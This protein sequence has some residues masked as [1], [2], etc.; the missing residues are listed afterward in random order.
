MSGPPTD[1]A[2]GAAAL[3]R[4]A[5]TLGGTGYVP[6]APGTAGSAVGAALYWTLYQGGAYWP[7]AVFPFVVILAVWSG[8]IVE[9]ETGRADPS[10]VVVDEAAG[11]LLCLMGFAPTAPLLV[12]GFLVFRFFDIWKPFRRIE[13]LPGGW[14]IVSDDLAAGALSWV[15]LALGRSSGYL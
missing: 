12:A 13:R 15:V 10:E 11:Q 3:A 14:G 5:A 7:A 6:I 8:G 9:R 1:G 2:G 4:I